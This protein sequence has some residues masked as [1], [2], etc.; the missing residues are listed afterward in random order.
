MMLLLLHP[1]PFLLHPCIIKALFSG[2]GKVKLIF[3]RTSL[4]KPKAILSIAACTLVAP[5]RV[6]GSIPPTEDDDYSSNSWIRQCDLN[7]NIS[8]FFARNLIF[9]N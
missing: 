1:T 7:N 4:A 6:P 9:F 5:L 3:W 2:N 8:S